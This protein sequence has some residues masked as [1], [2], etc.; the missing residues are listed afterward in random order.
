MIH[1]TSAYVGGQKA[2]KAQALQVSSLRRELGFQLA[3][4]TRSLRLTS[5]PLGSYCT[6]TGGWFQSDLRL[7]FQRR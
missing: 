1:C 2:M 5:D 4:N 3:L 7:H 6:T